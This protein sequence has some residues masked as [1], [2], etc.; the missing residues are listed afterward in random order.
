MDRRKAFFAA[1]ISTI[2]S[3]Y[4]CTALLHSYTGLSVNSSRRR[5]DGV[6]FSVLSEA[7]LPYG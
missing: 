4:S 5:S 6:L 2:L 7:P 3:Y 1:R